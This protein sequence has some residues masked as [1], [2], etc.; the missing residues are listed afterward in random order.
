M[1]LLLQWLGP[2]SLSLSPASLF[3]LF[4]FLFPSSFLSSSIFVSTKPLRSVVGG[5]F[6]H[7][8]FALFSSLER[9]PPCY[10]RVR[11]RAHA[12]RG[13]LV[14]LRESDSRT[15]QDASGRKEG[16]EAKFFFK[17]L[18]HCIIHHKYILSFARERERWGRLIRWPYL[19]LYE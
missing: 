1:T 4:L 11:R 18:I 2:L 5:F 16:N 12:S 6:F 7:F 15:D 8:I 14:S 9:Q 17:K 13:C 3:R 19:R 10:T